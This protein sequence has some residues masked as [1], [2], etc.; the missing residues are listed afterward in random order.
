MWEILNKLIN[1]GSVDPTI[2]MGCIEYE[3]KNKHDVAEEVRKKMLSSMP[4]GFVKVLS[5]N[6]VSSEETACHLVKEWEVYKGESGA[7]TQ[8][9]AAGSKQYE[10][11]AERAGLK[12]GKALLDLQE[13]LIDYLTSNERANLLE[14]AKFAHSYA[15]QINAASELKNGDR[16][17][18]SLSAV[19]RITMGRSYLEF[20][21]QASRGLLE[22]VSSSGMWVAMSAADES[23]WDAASAIYRRGAAL[24][25]I[26]L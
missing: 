18:V 20:D 3:L 13:C 2:S 5:D 6:G 4:C 7:T 24:S 25:A 22:N 14:C 23:T 26:R 9:E 19:E 15:V 12:D 21:E 17:V 8:S 16:C 10:R 11:L 1:L